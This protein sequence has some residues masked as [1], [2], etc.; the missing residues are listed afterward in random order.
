VRRPTTPLPTLAFAAAAALAVAA[1]PTAPAQ[2]QEQGGEAARRLALALR[3]DRDRVAERLGAAPLGDLPPGRLAALEALPPRAPELHPAEGLLARGVE[4]SFAGGDWGYAVG[5]RAEGTPLSG[6]SL[7]V[8]DGR[9][10][11]AHTGRTGTGVTFPGPRETLELE[12]VVAGPYVRVRVNGEEQLSLRRATG[13]PVEGRVGFGLG[14]GMVRFEEPEVLRHRVLG[15]DRVGR[16]ETYDEPLDPT[17]RG[18]FPWR[19]VVGRRVAGVPADPRGALLLWLPERPVPG[20]SRPA[21]RPA[22]EWFQKALAGSGVE[23]PLWLAV[24][25]GHEGDTREGVLDVPL[26]RGH[27]LR[28]HGH[29]DLAEALGAAY[30]PGGAAGHRVLPFP[31]VPAWLMLDERGVVRSAA[32]LTSL[33][34]AL[35][36]AHVLARR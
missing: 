16:L 15:P 5:N 25:V 32:P 26:D 31:E 21:L 36:L 8:S 7:G 24:P 2:E 20:G 28:H 23:P 4:V 29:A 14:R 13:G 10:Y 17:R 12:V 27:V 1:P 34:P 11:D 33:H 6:V 3:A 19:S 22:V 35:V 18:R 9:G 30:H